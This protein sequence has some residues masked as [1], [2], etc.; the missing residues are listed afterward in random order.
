MSLDISGIIK[1]WS[2]DPTSINA[3]WIIGSDGKP[4]VQLRLDL[5]LFQM[6]VEGRPDGRRPHGYDSLLEYY[7]SQERAST[8]TP[9]LNLDHE[10]CAGLQQE[11]MQYYYRYLAFYALRNLEGVIE[12][13][14]HNLAILDMVMD[15]AEDD[16]LSW[17]FEQFF[18]YIR[19]M[20]ARA[21]AE[22][23]VEAHPFEEAV[24][25]LEDA[26]DDLRRFWSENGENEM[27]SD[28][29]EAEL[30]NNLLRQ[31]RN[32]KPKS[33][34]DQLRE[35]LQRAVANENYE[36]A[37]A[38]RDRLAKQSQPQETTPDKCSAGPTGPA[39]RGGPPVKPLLTPRGTFG[40]LPRRARQPRAAQPLFEHNLDLDFPGLVIRAQFRLNQVCL[41]HVHEGLVAF[42]HDGQ[43]VFRLQER[44]R[45]VE[46][47]LRADVFEQA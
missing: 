28:C 17:Q 1:G 4:K 37:A 33:E 19:M 40:P 27:G 25:V 8:T 6:E 42:Q 35:E 38:L 2:Y 24:G 7:R 30:L 29:Q 18:P 23:A 16:D 5:G 10:A 46:V 43:R 12:D 21:R 45:N 31:V 11:A 34:A 13:T 9:A 14:E 3:R 32:Q 26:L 39:A 20:N 15:F 36:K 22:R 47:E 41:R 44:F